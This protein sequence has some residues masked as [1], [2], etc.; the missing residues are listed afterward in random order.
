M[1]HLMCSALSNKCFSNNNKLAVECSKSNEIEEK[2]LLTVLPSVL[3]YI[4]TI[5]NKFFRLEFVVGISRIYCINLKFNFTIV[6]YLLN[7]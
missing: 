3:T 6:F 1:Q 4:E 2:N 7:F 5:K